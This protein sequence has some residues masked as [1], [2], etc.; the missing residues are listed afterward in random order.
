MTPSSHQRRSGWCQPLPAHL[1]GAD[2]VTNGTITHRPLSFQFSDLFFRSALIPSS[3]RAFS[4]SSPS[5][6]QAG[7]QRQ[8]TTTPNWRGLGSKSGALSLNS[9]TSFLQARGRHTHLL[10]LYQHGPCSHTR[11]RSPVSSRRYGLRPAAR[12]PSPHRPLFPSLSTILISPPPISPKTNLPRPQHSSFD[13]MKQRRD[14]PQLSSIPGVISLP[15]RRSARSRRRRPSFSKGS[16]KDPIGPVYTTPEDTQ[17]I[18]SLLNLYPNINPSHNDNAFE[19]NYLAPSLPARRRR[20]PDP[21][22]SLDPAE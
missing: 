1:Y 9:L 8:P 6:Y 10:R 13:V 5:P 20:S 21:P 22:T 2:F 3:A 14:A 11:L 17:Y 19:S 16:D 7:Q 18:L 12:P 4:L 15:S